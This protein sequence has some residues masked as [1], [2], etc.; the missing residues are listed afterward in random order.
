MTDTIKITSLSPM[1]TTIP[2]ASLAPVVDMSGEPTT[3]KA[4]IANIAN[5]ILSQA[6]NGYVYAAKANLANVAGQ[7]TT[8]TQNA[9]P[10]ITS[11]GTLTSLTVSGETVLG[12]VGNVVITGGTNGYVLQTDGTGNLSWTA[13]TGGGGGNGTPGGANAQVQ[14]NDG[15]SFGGDPGLTFN[16][17]T[18]DLTVTGNVISTGGNVTANWVIGDYISGNAT[19]LHHIPG[20]NVTGFVPN[21]N[22]ANTAFAVAA[23][24]VSGLGNVA[25]VNFDGNSS[26]V[27]YGNGVFDSVGSPFNQDLNTTDNVTFANITSTDTIRFS[28]N[29][30]IVGAMGY[31]PTYVSIEG[32]QSNSVVVTAN[33]VYSWTFGSNGL[34]TLP[35]GAIIDTIGNNF[36]VRAV[37]NVNFEANAVVNIY[38]DG[39]G[40]AYQWQFGDDGNLTLP[41]NTFAV[42]YANGTP[43]PLGGSADLGNLEITGT[44]IGIASGSTE[45]AITVGS[46]QA[47]MIADNAEGAPIINIFAQGT[48]FFGFNQTTDYASGEWTASEGG[49]QITLTSVGV[50]FS[51]FLNT[52]GKYQSVTLDINEGTWTIPYDGYSS[53]G[54]TVVIFTTTSPAGATPP[55]TDPTAVTSIGFN[56]TFNNGL[57]LDPN[58]GDM[59]MRFDQYN[60]SITTDRDVNITVGDDLRLSGNDFVGLSGNGSVSITSDA[61]NTFNEWVFN[62]DASLTFPIKTVDLHNGGTQQARTLQ[63]G[64]SDY[65]AVI[66]GPTPDL[67][68]NA[69]RLIIQGQR[70]NG[71]GEGGDVYFWAG[72]ADT[73]GGDIKIYAGDADNVSA[74]SGGYVNI[75]GGSG[76]DDGG[77]VSIDGGESA[78]GTG[79]LV[80]ISGG[81]GN[82]RGGNVQIQSG[83]GYAGPGGAIVLTG[84]GS[85]NGLA[86]Y[87]NILVQA[88]V[89]TWTFDNSGNLI[90]PGSK[91]I[92][93]P[94]GTGGAAGS[95]ITI[96]AGQA[97]QSDFFTTKGGDVDIYGGTGA[98]NDGGG[99]GPGGN[100]NIVAGGSSDP[101]G[102]AGNINV[103]SGNSDWIFDYTGN[104]T[105]PNNIFSVNYANGSPVVLGSAALGNITVSDVTLQGVSGYSGGIQLSASP[106]DTANLKYLQVRSGDLDSHIHFDTG[107]NEAYDQYFGNDFKFLK[108]EAG[109][110]LS[111]NVQIGAY[112]DGGIGQLTWTFDTNGY[113]T[114]PRDTGPNTDP[115]LRISGGSAPSIVSVDASEAGPANLDINSNYLNFTGYN[116]NMVSIYA[117]DGEI[118][119]DS[120]IVLRTNRAGPDNSWT[121]GADGNLT[122]PGN[123]FAV[124]YANGTQVSLGGGYGDSNVVS[125]LSSFGSNTIS[126]TGNISTGAVTA[127]GKI[128]Y[129][130]GGTVTQTGTGQ[131]VTLNQLTGEITLAKSSWTAGDLEVFILT[132]NKVGANDYILAQTIDSVYAP[133][134]NVS[135]YY[136]SL[137]ANSIYVQ[138]KALETVTSTPKV[139]FF[140]MKAP[141]S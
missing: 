56:T 128:G 26:N 69:Q 95:N 121:F 51:N 15:G 91:T 40:N 74:G 25:L 42:N 102:H 1:G 98:S 39:S 84:G 63:L 123:T 12:P 80:D 130:T 82:S 110:G 45:T 119:S 27:L 16:K 109:T 131:G 100:I 140:I 59:L 33:D 61:G 79:G 107:N 9:Q 73:N 136:Y 124:N 19:P 55:A 90:L 2:G 29:G 112:Q 97:D 49:G 66:T 22:V 89:S 137:L 101:A 120:N 68:I 114:F 129:S 122:L 4:T 37:E 105:L 36:E 83:Y 3:K 99:G 44:T 54:G 94:P 125:L 58:E 8:V 57:Y 24:N 75:S 133:S 78:N 31:A 30:N 18:N 65:Q 6:G 32:Y 71:T 104:L 60:F 48:D 14:F 52:I 81:Q 50:D 135:A 127:T 38:T 132:N 41:G 47:Q 134:F 77:D 138:V 106:D 117:D 93:V 139:K 46:G 64:G 34:T 96:R 13:Q 141:I 67:D 126:T 62:S 20:A 111:G 43:V 88:G 103:S 17:T 70:G 108:L 116:D 113:L 115:Y 23:A 7:S 11:V 76:F 53:G 87:G 72:D 118:V 5:A 21:A 85:G 92:T 35:D 28:N 86:E 10:N